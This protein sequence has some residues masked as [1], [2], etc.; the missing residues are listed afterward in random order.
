MIP[1]GLK[2]RP[3]LAMSKCKH[4][5]YNGKIVEGAP[6][7][8]RQC[9]HNRKCYINDFVKASLGEAIKKSVVDLRLKARRDRM[10][11]EEA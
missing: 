6:Y 2:S 5:G 7:I 8:S 1:S 3:Y 4:C 10:E 11:Q 9:E